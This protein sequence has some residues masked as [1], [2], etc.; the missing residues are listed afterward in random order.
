VDR[1]RWTDQGASPRRERLTRASS[2]GAYEFVNMP[3]SDYFLVAV[4]DEFTANWQDP[5]QLDVLSRSATRVTVADGE[6]K[7]MDLTTARIR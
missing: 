4:S 1:R 6:R 3:A 7:T 2:K 5:R